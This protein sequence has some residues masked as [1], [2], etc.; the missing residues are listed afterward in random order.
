MSTPSSAFP[1]SRGSG[2]P[3]LCQNPSLGT[4]RRVAPFPMKLGPFPLAVLSAFLF[5]AASSHAGIAEAVDSDGVISISGSGGGG[6][7]YTGHTA[8]AGGSG[9]PAGTRRPYDRYTRQAAAPH[10]IPGSLL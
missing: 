3:D 9:A 1:V 8:D 2:G 7:S 4:P 10:P 6:P 5:G